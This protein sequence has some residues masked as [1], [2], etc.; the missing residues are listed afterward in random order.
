MPIPSDARPRA[1]GGASSRRL[2]SIVIPTYNRAHMVCDAIDAC[3]AQS[4][5]PLEVIVVNDGSQDDTAKVLERYQG[6]GKVRVFHKANEGIA[7]TLN[8]GFARS[9][10]RYVSWTSDD[11]Y[12][13]PKALET[14]A[15]YLDAHPDV[16]MVYA[17]VQ[18]IDADGRPVRVV[19]TGEPELLET[20]CTVR[21]CLLYRREVMK[22]VGGYR[23]RWVRCQDFDYY[24]RIYRR[25][26]VARI[27]E[28]LYAYRC[29]EASMSGDHRAHVT[30]HARLLS[31]YAADSA[32]RRA[33]WAWAFAELA[34]QETKRGR[35]WRTFYYHLRAALCQPYRARAL[36]PALWAAG[37]STLPEPLKRLWRRAKR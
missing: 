4:H 10:G 7:D 35:P 28:V 17:D 20:R 16:G 27:P 37:Y 9:R 21:G 5:R 25:F 36:R 12:Y 26:K 18:E 6:D 1:D 24:H 11:N 29:H 33:A 13:Y 23:R 2:V 15:D 34:R 31:T 22:A 14:M 8:F 3:L 30:E 32:G 19:N